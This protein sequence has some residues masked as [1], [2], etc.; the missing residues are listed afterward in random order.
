MNGI[1][2]DYV[3]IVRD[4]KYV[5]ELALS[6]PAQMQVHVNGISFQVSEILLTMHVIVN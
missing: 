2:W 5:R 4:V 6:L 3:W 1:R